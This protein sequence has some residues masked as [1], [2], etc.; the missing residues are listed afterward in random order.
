M[1][2]QYDMFGGCEEVKEPERKPTNK[3]KT[4]QEL[5]GYTEGHTCRTCENLLDA[6]YHNRTYYKCAIWKISHGSATDI[7]LKDKACGKWRGK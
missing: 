7:R 6:G 1:P 5:W 2:Q 4:M 3:F